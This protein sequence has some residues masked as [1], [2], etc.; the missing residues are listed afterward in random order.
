MH[1]ASLSSRQAGGYADICT[2]LLDAAAGPSTIDRGDSEGDTPLHNAARG[3]HDAVVQ[4]RR[5]DVVQRTA[6]CMSGCA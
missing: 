6:A 5:A 3:G 4:V 2:M 1:F